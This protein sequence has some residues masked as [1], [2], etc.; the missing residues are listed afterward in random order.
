MSR[1][2]SGEGRERNDSRVPIAGNREQAP[3]ICH[4]PSA[5]DPRRSLSAFTLMEIMVVV[6]IM[7]LIMAMG[8]PSLYRLLHREGFSKTV[9]DI[10]EMCSA[11]RA[12][13]ILQGTTTEI[14]FH[15]RERRCELGGT[16]AAGS[17]PAGSPG[18]SPGSVSFGD[19]VDLRM[20]DVNL[21]E[22]KDAPVARVRFFP[23]GTSDEMTLILHYMGSG[24]SD[25]RKIS[26]EITT[27]LASIDSDPDH[28]K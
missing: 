15:P 6:G 1:E 25:W 23:N 20:L 17:G 21:I 2:S 27:G 8:V 4:R 11:A 18:G 14:V 13:A 19:D 26:L 10:M 12:H 9:G 22:Y 28:W 7:G 3:A 16:G 5:R 24:N